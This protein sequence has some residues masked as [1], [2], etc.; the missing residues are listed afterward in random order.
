MQKYLT[1]SINNFVQVILHQTSTLVDVLIQFVAALVPTL[2]CKLQSFLFLL[3]GFDMPRLMRDT[4]NAKSTHVQTAITKVATL[5]PVPLIS[6]TLPHAI[7]FSTEGNLYTQESESK[8]DM[9][10]KTSINQRWIQALFSDLPFQHSND[11]GLKAGPGP[12]ELWLCSLRLLVNLMHH[13]PTTSI[14]LCSVPPTSS[15]SNPVVIYLGA[16]LR[17]FHDWRV[18]FASASLP[19]SAVTKASTT[20]VTPEETISVPGNLPGPLAPPF[21]PDKCSV[22]SSEAIQFTS[23]PSRARAPLLSPDEELLEVRLFLV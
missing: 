22:T 1:I 9:N 23:I 20:I 11:R 2:D 10:G 6:P 5:S 21:S 15:H 8:F 4:I 3:H 12:A 17:H 14:A 19:S 16:T 7:R 18:K 13:A